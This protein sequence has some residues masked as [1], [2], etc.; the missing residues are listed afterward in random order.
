MPESSTR[1]R[2][3][4]S[5]EALHIAGVSKLRRVDRKSQWAAQEAAERGRL[6]EKSGVTSTV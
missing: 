6:T 2:S 5:A 3:G 4:K 1:T